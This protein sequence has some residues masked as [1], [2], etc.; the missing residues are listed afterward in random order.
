MTLAGRIPNYS[1]GPV[2]E[3]H[4]LPYS[5]RKIGAPHAILFPLESVGDTWAE[6]NGLGRSY[7][8]PDPGNFEWL[9]KEVKWIAMAYH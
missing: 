1:G 2:P 3:F 6:V 7:S 9:L 4:R 5:P 8:L